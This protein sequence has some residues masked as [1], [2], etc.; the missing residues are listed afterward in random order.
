LFQQAYENLGHPPE[1]FND[2]LIEV[3]DHLLATP[4]LPDPIP[5]A[6]P[7]VQFEFADPNLEARSAGQKVLLRMGHENAL[8]SQRKAA[9]GARGAH[10]AAATA[11][12]RAHV[13]RMTDLNNRCSVPGLFT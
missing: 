11:V 9:R 10:R 13:R 6:R 1:Y 7:N 5:L 8:A 12:M 4:E 2:R 3:I